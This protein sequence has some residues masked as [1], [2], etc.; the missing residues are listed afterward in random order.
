MP[1]ARLPWGGTSGS[2]ETSRAWVAAGAVSPH[3]GGGGW[4]TAPPWRMDPPRPRGGAARWVV[5]SSPRRNVRNVGKPLGRTE[6]PAD[7]A[8]TTS[9]EAQKEL[10][11]TS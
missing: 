1:A 10:Q 9:A 3:G 7:P 5:V 2:D 11:N 8:Q 4:V 6:P